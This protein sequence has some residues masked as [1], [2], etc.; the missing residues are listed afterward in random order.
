LHHP[1]LAP[2]IDLAIKH[3]SVH[4]AHI[5]QH[6]QMTTASA[7]ALLKSFTPLFYPTD[8]TAKH[9]VYDCVAHRAVMAYHHEATLVDTVDDPR[10]HLPEIVRRYC[11]HHGKIHQLPVRMTDR[12]IV[13]RYI[14]QQLPDTPMT[15]PLINAEILH[16]VAFDDYATV[17]RDMVDLGFVMRTADGRVYQRIIDTSN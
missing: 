10:K 12:A 11:N 2:C 1:L 7:T 4:R 6:L 16:H 17:R 5:A 3:G 9:F 14:A 15:E 13:L 8:A